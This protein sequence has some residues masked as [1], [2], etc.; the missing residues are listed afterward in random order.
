MIQDRNSISEKAVWP[1]E[2]VFHLIGAAVL[3]HS[4]I[5][6]AVQLIYDGKVQ[7]SI[8]VGKLALNI[9]LVLT[10]MINLL[11]N[12]NKPINVRMTFAFT[13]CCKAALLFHNNVYFSTIMTAEICIT[14]VNFYKYRLDSL[15]LLPWNSLSASAAPYNVAYILINAT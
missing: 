8:R 1:S 15:C 2:R 4:P 12:S 13:C 5:L 10:G 11:T 7:H 3:P 6:I 14:G 9:C